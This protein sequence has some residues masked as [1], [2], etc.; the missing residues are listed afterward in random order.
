MQVRI[1]AFYLFELH[2]SLHARF[3]EP[4]G[5]N[6]AQRVAQCTLVQHMGC[7]KSYIRISKVTYRMAN[8]L[9]QEAVSRLEQSASPLCCSPPATQSVAAIWAGSAPYDEQNSELLCGFAELLSS[10]A[11]PRISPPAEESLDGSALDEVR[12]AEL[13]PMEFYNC[14]RHV[15]ASHCVCLQLLLF[16]RQARDHNQAGQ[17]RWALQF[18]LRRL[19]LGEQ[20]S[21]SSLCPR[22]G[23]NFWCPN[24]ADWRE[25]TDISSEVST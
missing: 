9:T 1:S 14:R 6:L 8:R 5:Q 7:Q 25:P 20:T 13:I 19:R 23:R 15:S 4:F 2:I 22:P 11:S 21:D 17:A 10:F 16:K 12:T 3:V 24:E 18:Q